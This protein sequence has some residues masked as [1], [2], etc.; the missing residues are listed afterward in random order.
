MGWLNWLKTFGCDHI[1]KYSGGPP[2]EFVFKSGEAFNP[3]V[4]QSRR[5]CQF[6]GVVQKVVVHQTE[7][8][9]SWEWKEP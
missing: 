2:P 6:C 7:G 9:I 4:R 1:W 8:M 5:E 3:P